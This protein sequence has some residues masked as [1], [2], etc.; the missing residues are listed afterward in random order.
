MAKTTDWLPGSR[1]DVLA[2]CANWISYLSKVRQTAWGIPEAEFTELDSFC[3][4]ATSLLQ[5]AR[6][7]AERTHVITVECQEAFKVLSA[8]MRFF[9]DRYFKIPPLSE[10]DWVALGFRQKDPHPSPVPAP[11]GV[12]VVTLSY[13]GGPHAITV[14]L[15]AMMGTQDLAAESDYGYAIYA[16]IMPPGGATL[17]QAASDKHYL[18]KIP[19][20]GKGLQ[21]YRFTRRGK[22][23]F[24]FDAEDAGKTVY[25]CCR[26]ENRKGEAGQWGPVVSLVIP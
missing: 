7:E 12:P 4:T 26:Y 3:S 5:K 19:M 21:H 1:T 11:D 14:H 23:K 17:E 8:K 10:G 25:V 18:M 16:G 20:D 22:E 24:I 9:R 6:D 2:M 15:G 13:P